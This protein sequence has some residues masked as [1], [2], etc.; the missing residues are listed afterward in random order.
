MSRNK[1][2]LVW[3]CLVLLKKVIIGTCREVFCLVN[4]WEAFVFMSRDFSF[5]PI[6][7]LWKAQE[8]K[9]SRS[10]INHKPLNFMNSMVRQVILTTRYTLS[11]SWLSTSKDVTNVFYA[12]CVL[13]S[14]NRRNAEIYPRACTP[15]K[16]IIE[17]DRR[18]KS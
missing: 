10:H 16:G 3:A 11:M 17:Y 4:S 12:Y 2:R 9:I 6:C 5:R 14:T 13:T 8:N 18:N 15:Y 1:G 7:V